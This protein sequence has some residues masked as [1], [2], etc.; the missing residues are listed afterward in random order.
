MS[1]ITLSN[2]AN[3]TD[4]N[5]AAGTINTNSAT[6]QGA[7]DNTLSRD[8]T[9]PNQ[10]LAPLD[11]NSNQIINLPAPQT[12]QSPLRLE[13]L[14]TF[15]GGGTIA[16]IP[17]GGTTNQVL[18]KTDNVDFHIGWKDSVTSVGLAMPADLTVTN[19]PV[20]TTGTLT[21]NWTST[22]TG[23][24]SMVRATSPSLTTPNIGA[25]TATTVNNVTITQPVATATL[26]MGSGKTLAVNNSL[27]IAGTDSTVMT[28]PAAS[29]SVLTA[30]STNTVTNKSIDAS[31]LTGSIAAARLGANT[32]S[33]ATLAQA[34]AYTLKG[35]TAA[36]T[37]NVSDFTING[38]TSKPVPVTTDTLLL[39]DSGASNALKSASIQALF[40]N[41][42]YPPGGRLTLTSVT[43]VMSAGVTGAS[44]VYYTPYQSNL[45][46]IFDGN[47]IN[48]T[49]FTE[50]SQAT[51]DATKSPA[52]VAASS[53]YDM[54]VWNDAG[55]V[56]CTRG[57]AWTND[58]TRGYTLT[59]T[60]GILLN[61]SA[62]TNG[63]GALRGT[64][65]GTIRSNGTSTIDWIYGGAS[66]AGNHCVWNTYNRIKVASTVI[67]TGASYTYTPTTVRQ[68]GGHTYN[69]VRWVCGLAEDAVEAYTNCS[70]Q[71]VSV[72]GAYAT[73]G[74]NID[75]TTGFYI[76]G[77]IAYNPVAAANSVALP[78]TSAFQPVVGYH[79][80]SR[81]EGSDGSHANT[82]NPSAND[83]LT[84]SV[85]M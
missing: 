7:M 33:N 62:I 41:S 13:D 61:T 12:A 53:V 6:I 19:S 20:T 76:S 42:Y 17:A 58:T 77:G 22:P 28:F 16:G 10:M 64:Y 45:V 30:D 3:L 38:L 78:W 52:A 54:F 35:N 83:W 65:V 46:P 21:A 57:P 80:V 24:G 40:V 1:K 37:G 36:T 59:M 15:N 48:M 43:P 74:A 72:A 49:Q 60:N 75:S 55:I 67:D 68:A 44:T 69:L 31:Q 25:A 85:V 81:N 66:T 50:L 23:T 4:V 5:T 11:M 47:Y 29:G 71:P 79:Y 14:N 82:F 63:P 18:S 34:A 73:F 27:T 32:V 8:G 70:V 51:T 39:A 2:V 9:A 26:N 56:R 84:V